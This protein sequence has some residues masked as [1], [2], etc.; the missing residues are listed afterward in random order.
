MTSSS[1]VVEEIGPDQAEKVGEFIL[2]AWRKAG[3]EALGWIGATEEVIRDLASR[4]HLKS[5]LADPNVK[6]FFAIDNGKGVGFAANRK[7]SNKEVELAGIIVIQ[8]SVGRGYG[9]AL[10]EK[11]RNWAVDHK[12]GRMIVKT[13]Q[14]NDRAISFYKSKG[15]RETEKVV[16][17]V[18]GKQVSIVVLELDL[19]AE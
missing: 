14:N 7:I 5:L 3:P 10:F 12:Y 19:T 8:D 4:N 18:Y 13:E 15:F 6:M 11:A 16:E 2:E 1:V 9:S 17:E